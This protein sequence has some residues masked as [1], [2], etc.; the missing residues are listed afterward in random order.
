MLSFLLSEGNIISVH[1]YCPLTNY[2]PNIIKLVEC[3]DDS[4]YIRI[5]DISQVNLND[6]IS[7]NLHICVLTSDYKYLKIDDKKEELEYPLS[8]IG[9]ILTKKNFNV[10]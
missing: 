6:S 2:E 1:A 5:T 4:I 9:C 8:L 7:V 3:K 10:N